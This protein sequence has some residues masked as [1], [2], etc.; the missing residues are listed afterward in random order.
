MGIHTGDGRLDADGDYVG[1]DVHRAARVAAAGH[2]GQVL[3][4]ETTAILVADELPPGVAPA[5]PRR[6]PA[7]GPA[8]RNGS[9]SSSSRACASRVSADPLARPPPQQPADPADQ[10]RRPRAGA[11]EAA[12][13][14]LATTRLLT[15]TGPGRD[16][17]D[18]AVAP[19]R[20]RRRGAV[21]RRDLVRRP[22]ARPRPGPDRRDD[23][24]DARARRD[25]R[26]A[27]PGRRSSTGWRDRE[28][29]LVLDNFEQVARRRPDRG[30]SPARAPRRLSVV[31]TSRA[32]LRVSRRAGVPGPGP[33]GP[34]RR[35]RPCPSSRR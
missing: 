20:R 25:R 16:R 19:A 9:A 13:E 18:A 14:L 23:P 15:L 31:V 11:G 17:Q 6:A 29:L 24:G 7:Q 21:R 22:R 5:R 2:G 33:A 12:G 27:G 1:A 35:P 26:P 8:A 10:L 30:R 4:S 32:P 3:L 34:A 28:V